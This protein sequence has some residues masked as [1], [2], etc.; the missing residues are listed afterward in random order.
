[1][2]RSPG[3]AEV[4]SRMLARRGGCGV[5]YRAILKKKKGKEIKRSWDVCVDTHRKKQRTGNTE[6]RPSQIK[7]L[8]SRAYILCSN[9][10]RLQL[11]QYGSASQVVDEVQKRSEE[12]TSELQSRENLVCRLL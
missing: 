7:T 12:H 2:H 4:V 8:C 5:R 9:R 6:K 11:G 3:R 1:D 10:Y